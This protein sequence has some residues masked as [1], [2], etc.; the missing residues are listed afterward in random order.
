MSEDK[1]EKLV[2]VFEVVGSF[3]AMIYSLLIASNSG[4]EIVGFTLLLLS[5]LLFSGW[6]IIEKRW[7]F[8]GLQIFYIVSAVIGFIRWS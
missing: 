6:G 8:L 4:N 3:L 2:K 5:A 7:S 1:R